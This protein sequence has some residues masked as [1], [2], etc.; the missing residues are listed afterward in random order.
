MLRYTDTAFLVLSCV[1]WGIFQ[2]VL[3]P[4][5]YLKREQ[6]CLRNRK[7]YLYPYSRQA[8]AKDNLP[9]IREGKAICNSKFAFSHGKFTSVCYTV[10]CRLC[11]LQLR[12]TLK[13]AVKFH[14]CSTSI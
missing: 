14:F 9:K 11:A 7:K 2:G 3:R 8:E 6:Q 1:E 5:K 12:S 10:S 13:D 4:T